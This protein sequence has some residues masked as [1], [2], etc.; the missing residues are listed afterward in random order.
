MNAPL[1]EGEVLVA[2]VSPRGPVATAARGTL[3]LSALEALR[4]HGVYDAFL[5][6][7]PEANRS[8]LLDASALRWLPIEHLL[9]MCLTV[10]RLKLTDRLLADVG[11]FAARTI[12]ATVLSVMLR[13]A[14][15]TP[16]TLLRSVDRVWDRFYE[17][18]VVTIVQLGP[19]DAHI[20]LSGL[21]HAVS[22]Y[23]RT[24]TQAFFQA[25]AGQLT[26]STYLTAARPR[27][28]SPLSFAFALSW[29]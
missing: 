9:A 13:S 1:L 15:A 21:P 2:H 6:E 17:G 12:G 26:R 8:A 10:D 4:K 24:T 11:G 22:R 18:G 23:C 3:V 19:K 29:V 7:L 27:T 20:E 14:G 28:P 25:L 16:W 5:A